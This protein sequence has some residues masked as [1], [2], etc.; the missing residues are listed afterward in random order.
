M[1]TLVDADPGRVLEVVDGQDSAGI[2]AWLAARSQTWRNAVEVVAIDP[3][4]A[5]R[6]AIP[7]SCLRRRSAS[8]RSTWPSSAT[9]WS[10][11]SGSKSLAR[12]RAAAATVGTRRLLLPAGDCLPRRAL[13]RLTATLAADDPTGEIDTARGVK[14]L[15]QQLLQPPTREEAAQRHTTLR[16]RRHHGNAR[17]RPT[18]RNRDRGVTS[19]RGPDRH[20]RHQRPTETANTSIKQTKRTSRG[21]PNPPT[22]TPL[23][24]SPAPPRRQREHLNHHR[25]SRPSASSPFSAP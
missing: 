11:G 22:T 6:Q 21:H 15:L 17:N 3:S 19:H 13:T 10:P 12:R 16:H 25:A 9:T 5:F 4:A 7:N 24:S 2:G 18:P 20:R 23:S 1:T 8:M 14:K